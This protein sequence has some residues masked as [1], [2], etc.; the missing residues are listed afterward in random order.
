MVD[1][2]AKYDARML[3]EPVTFQRKARTA[4]GRGGFTETWADISNAPTRGYMKPLSGA[5]RLQADRLDAVTRNRLVVRFFAG[6]KEEDRVVIR[7]R[8]YNIRFLNNVEF[9]DRWL[10][11]DL[12]GGVAT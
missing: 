9:R 8:S 4:N 6:L 11:I 2:C 1:K 10:E 3:R 5:E 7:S 12:D